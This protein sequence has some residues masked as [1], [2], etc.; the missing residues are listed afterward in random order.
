M[1]HKVEFQQSPFSKGWTDLT[2]GPQFQAAA[3]A[4]ML[5]FHSQQPIHSDMASA[6]ATEWRRQGAQQ[7]LDILVSLNI[8]PERRQPP[9]G[10]QLD[11]NA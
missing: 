3:K 10:K 11:H 6:A 8:N 4:A 1:N 5:H 9:T 7:F 2:D